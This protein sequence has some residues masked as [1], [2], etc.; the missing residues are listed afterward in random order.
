MSELAKIDL[1]WVQAFSD[2]HGRQRYY[3]RRRGYPRVA[4]PDDPGSP[5]FSA[6]YTAAKAQPRKS[7]TSPG[8][9]PRGIDA[10]VKAYYASEEFLSLR[11]STHKGYRSLLNDF[12]RV[13]GHLSA[14]RVQTAALDAIFEKR[15]ITRPGATRN[16]RKRLRRVFRVAIKLGWRTDNPV[17][18]TDPVK[19]RSNG[20]VPWSEE[21]I[22]AFE[23]KWP[24][25]TRPRLAMALLLYTG[26][27]RSDVVKMGA[28]HVRSGRIRVKQLKTD[29]LLA[30]RI[31]P[32]L[33]TEIDA[34]PKG[35]MFVVTQAGVPFSAQGFGQWFRERAE[36]AGVFGRNCHGLRKAAGRRM[37]EAGCSAKQIAA[38]LGHTTLTE[39][40]RYTRDADQAT[41]ADAAIASLGANS[42]TPV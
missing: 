15:S 6:A 26:Q 3:F 22:G 30:I 7:A 5:E 39:V 8:V 32:A 28:Q 17:M 21:E 19:H 1:P 25:G 41:L 29:N 42:G 14:E 27:R 35:M 12:S 40:E 33:Q 11:A 20:F 16:L 23:A 18:F 37:A 4:L 10:L 36:E 13:Y 31:H 2:R 38:V 9:D 24:S 34:A